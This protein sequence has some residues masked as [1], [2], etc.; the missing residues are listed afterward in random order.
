MNNRLTENWV[1]DAFGRL[2]RL[3]DEKDIRALTIPGIETND[4]PVGFAARFYA[5]R[6]HEIISLNME[7][8]PVDAKINL[9]TFEREASKEAASRMKGYLLYYEPMHCS[10]KFDVNE[11]SELFLLEDGRFAEVTS[12]TY[13]NGHDF[14]IHRKFRNIVKHKKDIWF[15]VKDL[16]AVL[17]L[18]WLSEFGGMPLG[19]MN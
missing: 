9:D 14:H 12:V 15:D 17:F 6:I 3:F 8:I 13:L 5:K 2:F 4:D 7:H 16:E 1:A 10:E 18:I 19:N 11:M